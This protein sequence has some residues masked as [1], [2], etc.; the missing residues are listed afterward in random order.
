[1]ELEKGG[2]GGLVEL[3]G[4]ARGGMSRIWDVLLEWVLLELYS[5]LNPIF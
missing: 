2:G 5:N 3:R 1:M 4:G